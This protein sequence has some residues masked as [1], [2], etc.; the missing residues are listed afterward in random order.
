M[1]KVLGILLVAASVLFA[2]TTTPP[3]GSDKSQPPPSPPPSPSASQPAPKPAPRKPPRSG[4][5]NPEETGGARGFGLHL[6]GTVLDAEEHAI[7]AAKVRLSAEEPGE[8]TREASADAEGKF[9]IR[10]ERA[11]TYTLEISRPGFRTLKQ[12][13]LKL[14]SLLCSVRSTMQAGAAENIQTVSF[15]ELRGRVRSTEGD[16]VPE[17]QLEFTPAGSTKPVVVA[18]DADGEFRAANFQT[19]SY[20]LRITAAGYAPQEDANFQVHA[21]TP[22]RPASF[23]FELKKAK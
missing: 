13:G 15:L 11:G 4:S 22:L 18:T 3:A 10:V 17:A 19:G 1:S 16:A 6:R 23:S 12:P 14:D 21:S 2:Q 7:A 20:K 8:P 5:I 9:Q